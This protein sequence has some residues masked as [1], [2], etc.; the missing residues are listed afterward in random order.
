MADSALVAKLAEATQVTR[1][2][3]AYCKNDRR[4]ISERAPFCNAI[5]A[6]YAKVSEHCPSALGIAVNPGECENALQEYMNAAMGKYPCGSI[7][8]QH[9]NADTEWFAKR[10][11]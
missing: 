6:L 4:P 9:G 1:T 3:G 10:C 11:D 8:V 5:P 7:V 2:I